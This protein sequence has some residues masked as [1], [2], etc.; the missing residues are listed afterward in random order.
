MGSMRG[1]LERNR[2]MVIAV[3]VLAILLAVFQAFRGSGRSQA[4]G[5]D[6][7]LELAR[8]I[9]Q[10]IVAAG[11]EVFALPQ[12][13]LGEKT[14]ESFRRLNSSLPPIERLGQL[15]DIVQAGVNQGDLVG[16]GYMVILQGHRWNSGFLVAAAD[17]VYS[18]TGWFTGCTRVQMLR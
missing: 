8:G 9:S 7:V 4:A 10:A 18:C 14:W 17:G 15:V 5:K 6:E 2:Y 13:P 3:A 1:L 12:G 11:N 16:K